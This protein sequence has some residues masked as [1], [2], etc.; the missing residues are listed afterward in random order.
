[1]QDFIIAHGWQWAMSCVSWFLQSIG[2]TGAAALVAGGLLVAGTSAKGIKLLSQPRGMAV[3]AGLLVAG[4]LC[5]WWFWPMA[6]AAGPRVATPVTAATVTQAKGQAAKR[7]AV[8]KPFKKAVVTAAKKKQPLPGPLPLMAGQPFTLIPLPMTGGMIRLPTMPLLRPPPGKPHAAA[9]H[10]GV[11]ASHGTAAPSSRAGGALAA[12]TPQARPLAASKTAPT[13]GPVA[14]ATPASKP[15]GASTPPSTRKRSTPPPSASPG[16][17]A[18][19]G[20]GGSTGNNGGLALMHQGGGNA[21]PMVPPMQQPQRQQ[22]GGM[23]APD[24]DIILWHWMN[25]QM[26][27]MGEGPHVHMQP[28]HQGGQMGAV[29]GGSPHV[30]RR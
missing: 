10:S 25:E 13:S 4:L 29:H 6:V 30:G 5:A 26:G 3:S 21:S 9:G 7:A 23:R 11:I 2:P 24:V 12:A 18:R 19:R 20:A 16:A 17:V 22:G 1:M 14:S 27:G 28:M 15:R 8:A